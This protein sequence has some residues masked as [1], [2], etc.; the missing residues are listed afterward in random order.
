M[1]QNKNIILILVL[2]L[3]ISMSINAQ[4]LRLKPFD[5]TP[6]TYLVAQI[7]ADTLANKGILPNRIYEL[8]SGQIYLNT[9][10]FN[11]AAKYT[12]R[13]RSSGTAKPIIY[14]YP[15]GTG[16]NPQ[17]PPGQLFQLN[18]GHLE[19]TNIAVS[20]YFEPLYDAFNNVQGGLINTAAEG[21]RIIIDKCLLTNVNG[22]PVRTGSATKVVKVTNSI[23]ANMGALSTSNLGAG[24]GIDLRE[25]SCDSLILVNNTFVNYQDRVIR[26]YNFANPLAGT[27]GIKYCLIDHNTLV[28]GMG[29]HGTLS[30]GNVGKDVIITNNLFLDG[31]SAGEDSTD[32]TRTAEWGNTGEK[33]ANGNNYMCWIFTAPNDTTKWKVSNNFYAISKEGQAFFDKYKFKEGSPLSR[34]IRSKLGA[35]AAKAF[36][37]VNLTMN[38]IPKLMVNMMEW[39]LDPNGGNKTKNTPSSKWVRE[40]HDMDRRTYKYFIDTM[41]CAFPKTVPAYYSA[42]RGFPAG[43]LNWFPALKS[44]WEKG[45]S[46]DVETHDEIPVEYSLEQNYPNPFNPTTTISFVIPKSG[47]TTLSV[48]N[49][50]GEKIATIVNEN[51]NAGHHEFSFN[52]QNLPSGIYFY[53]LESGSF[54]Q[55]KK[56]ILMK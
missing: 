52:A 14:Q 26:H 30:L 5:G 19:M 37:K 56:M 8:E 33:Y 13:M 12:L 45:G 55:T 16:A 31:F 47:L 6:A 28:N 18:G 20:G 42:E 46:V 3:L 17:N 35:N 10:V 1:L 32:A 51:L 2:T 38:R 49:L 15:S 40:L 53:K 22:Q 39:Y 7:K 54:S 48:Y 23:F 11:V 9:E 34:H 24:K 36:T 41:D 50:I 27:G 21:S 4:V 43:D 29:F 25:A 44:I